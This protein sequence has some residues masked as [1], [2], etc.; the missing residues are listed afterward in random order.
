MPLLGMRFCECR[1]VL[2]LITV[3]SPFSIVDGDEDKENIRRG[4]V[5]ADDAGGRQKLLRTVRS[6]E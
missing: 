5:G 6:G 2:E 3:F 4:V 1:H